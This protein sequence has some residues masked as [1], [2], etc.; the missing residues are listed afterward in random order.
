MRYAPIIVMMPAPMKKKEKKKKPS[1]KAKKEPT[2]A[3][4]TP[5][6][7]TSWYSL[8]AITKA[9]ALPIRPMTA[10]TLPKPQRILNEMFR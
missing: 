8:Q 5:G 2:S 7:R 3:S 6:G 9:P 1:A 10:A 4:A